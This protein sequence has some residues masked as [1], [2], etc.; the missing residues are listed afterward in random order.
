VLL[1]TLRASN[2][3][4]KKAIISLDPKEQ[5]QKETYENFERGKFLWLQ[6]T[7]AKQAGMPGKLIEPLYRQLGIEPEDEQKIKE[8][9]DKEKRQKKLDELYRTFLKYFLLA[10]SDEVRRK[11]CLI[12]IMEKN[13]I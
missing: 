7:K 5:A 8:R 13:R 10:T 1:G 4:R 12:Y 9:K 3:E 11:L 2:L 6:I